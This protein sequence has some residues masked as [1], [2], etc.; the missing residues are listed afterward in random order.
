[1]LRIF[2]LKIESASLYLS[3]HL[4]TYLKKFL[5]FLYPRLRERTYINKKGQ[6]A[7]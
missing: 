1:M 6:P 5:K 7:V 4:V 3:P 2:L